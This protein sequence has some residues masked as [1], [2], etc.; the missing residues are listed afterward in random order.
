L[1]DLDSNQWGCYQAGEATTYT[2]QVADPGVVYTFQAPDDSGGSLIP[3]DGYWFIAYG[4]LDKGTPSEAFSNPV[5]V[6]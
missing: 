4:T 1:V 3:G 6:P 2:S 5:Q